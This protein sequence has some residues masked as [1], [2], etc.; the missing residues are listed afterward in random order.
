MRPVP[1]STQTLSILADQVFPELNKKPTSRKKSWSG[2]LEAFLKKEGTWR[3]IFDASDIGTERNLIADRLVVEDAQVLDVGCGKG[4]FSFACAARSAEV[5][6]LDLMDGG[7]RTGWWNEFKKTSAILGHAQRISGIR[8]SA[9]SIPLRRGSVQLV[10]SVHS[11]RNFGSVEEIRGFTREASRVLR[12]GGCLA[13][14]ESDLSDPECPG[15]RAFYSMRTRMGWELD[16]PSCAELARF[17]EAE[18]FHDVSQEFIESGL[19]YAPICFPYDPSRL[20]GMK[21]EYENA[22]KLLMD[23]AEKRPRICLTSGKR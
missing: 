11:L 17:F 5:T 10:A 4:F 21:D 2:T 22:E 16:L 3:D 1:E 19:D 15:Y 12:K 14:A 9:T 6:S 8:A 7:G 23:E 18:G 13:V 20:K